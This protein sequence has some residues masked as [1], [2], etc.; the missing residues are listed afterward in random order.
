V[1]HKN[2]KSSNI[3]L[4]GDLN[5]HL[6][7]SGFADLIANPDPQVIYINQGKKFLND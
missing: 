6:S 1:L 3:L 2:F 4:D 5:P 7:D